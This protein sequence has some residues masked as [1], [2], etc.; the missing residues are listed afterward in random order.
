MFKED[1]E[2]RSAVFRKM[3]Y[4]HIDLY[5][6]VE[7]E[8]YLIWRLPDSDREEWWRNLPPIETSW[9]VCAKYLI[10]FMRERGWNY[11]IVSGQ[12]SWEW[13]SWEKQHSVDVI[14]H[15]IALAACKAFMEV[16]V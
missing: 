9:E 16:S 6:D 5:D 14:D 7:I 10:P 4:I 13:A 11:H 3:G 2:L 15:N 12:F 8:P 1:L